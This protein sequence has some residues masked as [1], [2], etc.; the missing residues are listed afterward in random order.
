MLHLDSFGSKPVTESLKQSFG[1]QPF[2]LPDGTHTGSGQ[3]IKPVRLLDGSLRHRPRYLH[4]DECN[5]RQFSSFVRNNENLSRMYED[6]ISESLSFIGGIKGKSYLDIACNAG[7]FPVRM[8][9]LGAKTSTGVDAFDHAPNINL[10]NQVLSTD[11]S[12][13]NQPYSSLTHNISNL[14]PAFDVVSSIA[15]MLHI[16]D[17]TYLLSYLCSL[18]SHAVILA[19]QVSFDNSLSV[20][21]SDKVNRYYDSPF[22]VCFDAMTMITDNLI[23]TGFQLSGF[24]HIKRIKRRSYWRY[25]RHFHAY[26]AFK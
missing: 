6:I 22:P 8:S 26:V 10:C 4:P 18:S 24:S 7:Y 23:K 25:G 3:L 20:T 15:F 13:I 16:S 12:F 9:Q 17:P 1:Y 2:I 21:Y 14:E 11:V 19:T 5:P